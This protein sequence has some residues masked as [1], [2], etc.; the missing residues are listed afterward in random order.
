MRKK[1][2]TLLPENRTFFETAANQHNL[3]FTAEDKETSGGEK[4]VIIWIEFNHT[5]FAMELVV[6]LYREMKDNHLKS[7]NKIFTE[8]HA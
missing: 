1:L 8:S 7:F 6:P 5:T 4:M 3:P 2:C